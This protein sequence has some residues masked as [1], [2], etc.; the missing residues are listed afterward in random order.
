MTKVAGLYIISNVVH[1]VG[2]GYHGQQN[3][4]KGRRCCVCNQS[5][6][7]LKREVWQRS[8]KPFVMQMRL[9]G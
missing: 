5:T 3:T 9:L 2:C 8:L 6:L 7:A 1:C 4:Q